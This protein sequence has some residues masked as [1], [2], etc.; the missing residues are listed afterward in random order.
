MAAIA[1]SGVALFTVSRKRIEAPSWTLGSLVMGAGMT[2]CATTSTSATKPS[3][4]T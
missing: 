2:W 3:C 4:G 1:A